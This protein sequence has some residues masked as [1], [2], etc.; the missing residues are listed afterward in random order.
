MT[1][2]PKL[3]RR[4]VIAI[5]LALGG[6]L[7]LS[8]V[9]TKVLVASKRSILIPDFRIDPNALRYIAEK[10]FDS[11]PAERSAQYLKSQLLE[12]VAARA[13]DESMAQAIA[14]NIRSDFEKRDTVVLD[15]WL[16]SRTEVR[17]WVLCDLM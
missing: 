6:T 8:S 12:A 15:G 16:L 7:G 5:V 17:L 11:Y 4:Q 13:A 14:A 1:N 10:Y 3:T 2:G 9:A